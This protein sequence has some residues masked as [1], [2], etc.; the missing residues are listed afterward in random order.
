MQ[1]LKMQKMPNKMILKCI[2]MLI[3]KKQ[4]SR[5]HKMIMPNI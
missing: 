3:K 4:F 5:L 2:C 1:L